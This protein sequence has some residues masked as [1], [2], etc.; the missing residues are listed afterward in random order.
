MSMRPQNP[1]G[2]RHSTRLPTKLKDPKQIEIFARSELYD[3]E[4]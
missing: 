3:N 1:M 2:P 4:F